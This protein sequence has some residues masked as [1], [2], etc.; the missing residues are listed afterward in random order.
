MAMKFS[1][2]AIGFAL[3]SVAQPAPLIVHTGES[4]V[5]TIKDGQP[6]NPHKATAST[7]PEKGQ[8]MVTVRALFG[9]TMF[10]TNNSKI[11]YT[12]RA[13]LLSNGETTAA[14][15]CTLP[16]TGRPVMEQWEQKS[17]GVRISDFRASGTEGRC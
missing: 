7:K 16:A 2:G 13:E 5:F 4:W 11:A 6:A 14:R 8:V 10:V 17:D 15:S 3:A 9:T 12:Y 1:I